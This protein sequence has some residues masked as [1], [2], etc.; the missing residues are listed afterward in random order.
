[1][2]IRESNRGGVKMQHAYQFEFESILLKPLMEADIEELR[3]LRNR[4]KQ[5]FS[6]Q[7]EITREGQKQWYQKYL[8]KADDI[9]F[10]IVKHDNPDLFIGAIALYDIDWEQRIAEC[11]RTVLDKSLAP[12]KGIGQEATKAVCLFGFEVLKIRKIVAEVLKSNERIIKVD[13]RAGFYIVGEHEDVYEIEMTPESI[14][15]SG[16]ERQ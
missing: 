2:K 12:E 1:M 10:K 5:Y 8:N 16:K 9:M 4:E 7:D 11:G 3:V 14:Q 13:K 15:L 6:S